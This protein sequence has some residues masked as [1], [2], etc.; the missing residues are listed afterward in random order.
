M[1]KEKFDAA[2][3]AKSIRSDFSLGDSGSISAEKGFVDKFLAARAPGK[4]E[5]DLIENQ[6]IISDLVDTITLVAGQASIAGFKAN[7][8][9]ADTE[10]K[11]KIGN[12]KVKFNMTR[13]T[14]V[15]DG[16]GGRMTKHGATR[17]GYLVSGGSN[18]GSIKKVRD[19]LSSEAAELLAD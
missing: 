3:L 5:K 4:T 1:S 11:F 9:L 14:E 15:S 19:Q 10:G 12:D 8:D 16:K 13:Q 17:I 7:K 2:E 18:N 6:Q